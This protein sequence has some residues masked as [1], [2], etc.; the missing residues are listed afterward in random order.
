[1]HGFQITDYLETD[2]R[3]HLHTSAA[4]CAVASP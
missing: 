2:R 1:M 4:N 3:V